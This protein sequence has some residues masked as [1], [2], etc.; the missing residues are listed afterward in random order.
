[1]FH[2][3]SLMKQRTMPLSRG[4]AHT[5]H[6][7]LCL[8]CPIFTQWFQCPTKISVFW[9]IQDAQE[10]SKIQ[11]E[12]WWSVLWL[13]LGKRG[14]QNPWRLHFPFGQESNGILRTTYGQWTLLYS[15]FLM[16]L[17]FISQTC[18]LTLITEK[19]REW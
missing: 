15:F 5:R 3:W 7:A 1:M 19:E 8:R 14:K 9:G 11:N 17:F 4:S 13:W 16:L 18:M 2:K 6:I 12:C 10:F